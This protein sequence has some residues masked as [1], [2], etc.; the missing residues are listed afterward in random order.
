MSTQSGG[1]NRIIG[2]VLAGIVLLLGP[3][4]YRLSVMGVNQRSYSDSVTA[5]LISAAPEPTATAIVLANQRA[6]AEPDLRTGPVVV[7]FAHFNLVNPAGLQPLAAALAQRGLATRIWFS[8]VDPFLLESAGD[9]PDQ[10]SEL[11]DQLADASAMVV[12]S[13]FFWWQ[14]AEIDLL[15]RFVSDGGRLLIISDPDVVGDAA[16]YMNLLAERFG[17]V[18]ND[19]YLYD[20]TRNDENYTHFFLDGFAGAG[21][22]LEGSTIAMYG[23]RSISGDVTAAARSAP[24]TRSSRRSGV[25]GFTT[26]AIGG[27]SGRGTTGRVLALAD[28]DVLTEPNVTRFDNQRLVDF[29]ADF[30]AAAQRDAG[31]P[32]F[33]AALGKD[34]TLNIAMEG[35][36][37]ADT[38]LLGARLQRRLEETGRTLTLAGAPQVASAAPT[39]EAGAPR[40]VTPASAGPPTNGTGASTEPPASGTSGAGSVG[41]S[42]DMVVLSDYDYAN[43]KSGLLASVGITVVTELVTP[44]VA[45]TA[46]LPQRHCRHPPPGAARCLCPRPSRRCRRS[47]PP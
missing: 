8:K 28:F 42:L 19:D 9:I 17:V 34:V 29:T 24:T 3:V 6:A 26:V 35:A 4:T 32:D 12:I 16:V 27:D 31:V 23:G 39:A 46:P 41:D 40:V 14:T 18:Y 7:D 21:E 10:S 5:P 2:L 1:R 25:S 13:P 45:A 33:P 43:G 36:L 11:R 37:N 47:R 44:T 22:A 38:L 15:E 20:T 30:L